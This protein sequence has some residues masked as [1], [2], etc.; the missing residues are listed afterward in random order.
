MCERQIAPRE[1]GSPRTKDEGGTQSLEVDGGKADENAKLKLLSRENEARDAT[2]IKMTF[3]FWEMWA[4]PWAMI[5][6]EER[7]KM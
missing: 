2:Q 4:L 6:T 7:T 5:K 1:W 3:L